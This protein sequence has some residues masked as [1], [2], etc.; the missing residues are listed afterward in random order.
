MMIMMEMGF[1][2]N[3]LP[4]LAEWSWTRSFRN[5]GSYELWSYH[6]GSSRFPTASS[7]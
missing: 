6:P 7:F 4:F 1:F 3:D 5:W 2:S